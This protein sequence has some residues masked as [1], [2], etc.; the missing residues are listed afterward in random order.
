[1][2]LGGKREKTVGGHLSELGGVVGE[3]HSKAVWR[4]VEQSGALQK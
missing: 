2:F 1:M 3:K 4:S